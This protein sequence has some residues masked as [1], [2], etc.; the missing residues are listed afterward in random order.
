MSHFISVYSS[1]EVCMME[2]W[3]QFYK[4]RAFSKPKVTKSSKF[5]FKG[6]YPFISLTSFFW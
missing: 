2:K 6:Y 4:N 1:K 3:S 5:D